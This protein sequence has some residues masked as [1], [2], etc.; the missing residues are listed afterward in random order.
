MKKRIKLFTIILFSMCIIGTNIL[1][2]HAGNVTLSFKGN[3]TVKV[4]D[5][6]T[7]TVAVSDINGLT[8]GLATAQGDLIFDENY[9]EYVS[10]K[11][12]S[13]NL[14]VSYGTKAKRFVALGMGGEYVSSSDNFFT[15]TFK[16]KKVGTTTLNI[17][18]VIV[19]DTKS[20]IHS[21][22]IIQKTITIVDGT[23]QE[24]TAPTTPT[25]KPSNKKPQMNSSVKKDTDSEKNSDN[26]LSKLLVNNAKMSPKFEK[27]VT[28]Y[29]VVIPK[30]TNKLDLS[31]ITSDSKATVKVVGNSD[32]KDGKNNVVEVIVT[33]EDGSTKTYTLNVT[34]SNDSSS[35]KLILLNVK[36]GSLSGRF[37]SDVYEYNITV[38]KMTN[39]LTINAI[40]ENKNSKVEI[41]GNKNL[42]KTSVILVKLTD[43]NGYNSYYRLNVK[44]SNSLN[45]LVKYLIIGLIFLFFFLFLLLL[46]LKRKK[47]E[48][49]EVK[50]E[51]IP[52]EIN[53]STNNDDLYDDIVTKDEIISAIEE[54]N[55]KKLRMLLKQEEVNKLKEECKIGQDL[56]DDIVTK[57][58]LIDAI[59]EQN[60]KKL[61]MLLD[62][63][64]VNKL[65]DEALIAKNPDKP[66]VT[67]DEL[68]SALE[69]ND[70]QKLNL[71][72][73]QEE[74]NRL[75][76]E[77]RAEE[78]RNN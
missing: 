52:T 34:K 20:I 31:Y 22:N 23:S 77:L 40:P 47:D 58:E 57:E 35:N 16:A 54:K 44:Q 30:N 41:I 18:D 3:D 72:L 53:G 65:R 70:Q 9:L 39:K 55:P 49:E 45:P 10:F 27:D 32:L 73:K 15:L 21:S 46:L 4:N 14:S 37:D 64:E 8:N 36:E 74:V 38:P 11:A 2:V 1:S 43:K 5:N 78:K 28:S 67:K 48:E 66:D 60:P 71:L 29:N 42:G 63:E 51:E 26:N 13:Q 69:D 61:K 12:V 19:G 62:Q 56:Y 24:P 68:I 75:K 17:K 6:I 33:A 50:K 25:K 76:D 7:I 59:E